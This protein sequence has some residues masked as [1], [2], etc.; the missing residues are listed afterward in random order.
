MA[1]STPFGRA[2]RSKYFS[3]REDHVPLNHGSFGAFPLI[4]KE[5]LI[6]LIDQCENDV[7][8]YTRYDYPREMEKSRKI[9]SELINVDSSTVV[10]V[11]NVTTAIN[12]V[13]RSLTW[14]PGDI[15]ITLDICK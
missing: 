8:K 11:P 15:I 9:V 4:V 2:F 6:S 12:A 1:Q 7:D 13:L 5:K 10:F 3:Y 14:A